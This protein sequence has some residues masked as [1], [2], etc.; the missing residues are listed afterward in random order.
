MNGTKSFQVNCSA[1]VEWAV[2]L[3]HV[4]VSRLDSRQRFFRSP[5]WFDDVYSVANHPFPMIPVM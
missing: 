2:G 1:I 5:W 3:E 4:D